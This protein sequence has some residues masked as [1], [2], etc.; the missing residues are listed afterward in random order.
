MS[1]GGAAQRRAVLLAA[2]RLAALFAVVFYGADAL[3]ALRE[4]RFQVHMAWE[5]AMPYW[6]PAWLI[7]FSVFAVPLL[8]LTMLPD[9][10]HVRRWEWRMAMAVLLAGAIFVVLPAELAY[11]PADAGRW[12]PLADLAQLVAG[13][14][15]LL[16]SLHVAL[17]LLT[18]QAVWP[19]AGP[20]VR[21]AL[22]VWYGLLVASVLL[23]HQHHVADVAAGLLLAVLIRVANARLRAR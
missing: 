13:R 8:P 3:T 5:L 18:L 7:Y 23:T 10:Q 20:R 4:T 17:S 9:T 1:G 14:Y 6:P 21:I 2:L 16:P 12:S 19:F 11:P 22:A 15:N